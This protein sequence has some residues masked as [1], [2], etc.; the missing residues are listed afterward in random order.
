MK[1]KWWL[2]N[3]RDLYNGYLVDVRFLLTQQFW[4]LPRACPPRLISNS[5]HIFWPPNMNRSM[6]QNQGVK[7]V[8]IEFYQCIL[9]EGIGCY[10]RFYRL[11]LKFIIFQAQMMFD[12]EGERHKLLICGLFTIDVFLRWYIKCIMHIMCMTS[13]R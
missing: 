13:Q 5:L 7:G 1:D 4:D 8:L 11:W 10:T 6:I 9:G 2:G 12:P 3:I